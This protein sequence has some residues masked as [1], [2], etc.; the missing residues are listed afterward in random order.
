MSMADELAL[1]GRSFIKMRNKRGPRMLPCGP[2]DITGNKLDLLPLIE[3][4]CSL[5]DK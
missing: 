4:H 2:P 3:I 1:S 5:L